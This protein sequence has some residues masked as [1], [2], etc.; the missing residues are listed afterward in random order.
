MR[1]TNLL[2]IIFVIIWGTCYSQPSYPI[3][4]ILKGDSVVILTKKQ[5][6]NIN[7]LI[8]NQRIRIQNF[9]T[10]IKSIT[11]TNNVLKNEIVVKENIIDSLKN[12]LSNKNTNYDSLINKMDTLESW[13]LDL[14]INNG[15]LYYSWQDSTVKV[16]DL[17]SYMMILN[18]KTGNYS[19]IDR[20]N[21]FDINYWR[22]K[23][24]L[25]QESP[26]IGWELNVSPKY[27][28]RIVLF[29]YK[30]TPKL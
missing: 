27:K 30:L 25:E 22:E 11:D 28:P 17:S 26:E 6:D 8:D 19:L 10:E 2:V 24:L 15:Y 18:R 20:G 1:L 12:V 14:S 21:T 29:P 23:N 4:T 7:L 9:K 13:I 5:S 3:Q 16:I